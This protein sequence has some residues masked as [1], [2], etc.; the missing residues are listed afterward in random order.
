VLGE[1]TEKRKEIKTKKKELEA[2]SAA[3]EEAV[4]KQPD[5]YKHIRHYFDA[6]VKKVVNRHGNLYA[7]VNTKGHLEFDVE[8]LDDAAKPTSAG[9]GFSYGRLL[10]I[11]FDLAIMRAYVTDPFPHFVFH[12]GLLETLDDRKKLNLIDVSRE[13]CKLGIQHIVTVIESELPRMS[14]GKAFAFTADETILV[15][16]D[17]GASGRLFKMPSW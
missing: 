13:Y 3:L 6:I 12:D 16:T 9:Q 8:V 14:N 5:R 17:E 1:L 10:C 4:A 2:V 11:A 7:R 15:L